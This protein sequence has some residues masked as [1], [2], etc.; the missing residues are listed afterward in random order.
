M[1]G[2]A[3]ERCYPC[4]R[5]AR[6]VVGWWSETELWTGVALAELCCC[7]AHCTVKVKPIASHREHPLHFQPINDGDTIE[8]SRKRFEG[9]MD[10]LWQLELGF[11]SFHDHLRLDTPNGL[12]LPM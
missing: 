5:I 2:N 3:H 7:V 9:D 11:L 4:Q 6:K 8:R 10:Q 1:M 12:C